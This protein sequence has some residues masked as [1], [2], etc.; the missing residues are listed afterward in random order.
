MEEV[1]PS[2]WGYG[3]MNSICTCLV[4]ILAAASFQQIWLQMRKPIVVT[5]CWNG[6]I[7]R[8]K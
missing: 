2:F 8:L 7:K 5:N 3:T 6:D 4:L 1:T